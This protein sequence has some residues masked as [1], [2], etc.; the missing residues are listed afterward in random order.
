MNATHTYMYR[1]FEHV[2]SKLGRVEKT[3]RLI[4]Y[5]NK[6]NWFTEMYLTTMSN[7]QMLSY[8]DI[9][10]LW[11]LCTHSPFVMDNDAVK[12]RTNLTW[13]I[14]IGTVRRNIGIAST[15][16]IRSA[17]GC[18]ICGGFTGYVCWKAF[19]LVSLS[20]SVLPLAEDVWYFLVSFLTQC[21]VIINRCHIFMP[22]YLHNIYRS[23][24]HCFLLT[25]GRDKI[26]SGTDWL[27]SHLQL[28]FIFFMR[29]ESFLHALFYLFLKLVQINY[30]FCDNASI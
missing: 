22:W 4:I 28:S 16:N 11:K 27:M 30:V 10:H 9:S 1:R 25:S 3:E 15:R 26:F 18:R 2:L 7:T 13:H 14:C 21:W 19:L 17:T 5:L 8:W 24:P 6:L 29:L 20:V 23:P 12:H